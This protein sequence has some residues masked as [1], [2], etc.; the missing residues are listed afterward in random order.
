MLTK[1]AAVD[2]FLHGHH[3]GIMICRAA[4]QLCIQRSDKTSICDGTC[5]SAFRQ[6][7]PDLFRRSHHAAHCKQKDS[8]LITDDFRL[9]EFKRRITGTQPVVGSAAGIA[10]GDRSIQGE[11]KTKHICKLPPVFRCHHCHARNRGHV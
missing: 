3:H 1:A 7:F 5:Q 9:S 10:D 4:K 6:D 11:G 8:A 2:V